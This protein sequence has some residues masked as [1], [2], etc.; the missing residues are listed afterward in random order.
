MAPRTDFPPVRACLFDMDGLLLDTEDLYTACINI[1]LEQNGRPLLPWSIKA[2]LQGRPG[3]DA[4]RLFHEWAQLPIPHDE[5]Q[6]KLSALQRQIFPATKPLPGVPALLANLGRT[7]YWDLSPTADGA[8][9]DKKN[10]RVHIAL[11]TSSHLANFKL[12]SDHLT[13]LFS[14]FPSDRR[15]LGD[16]K[17]IAPGRG[18]PN[19]DIFLLALKTINDSLPAGESPI[20]PEECLVFE[21]SVPG[22]EAGRRAGMRV[23][24]CPHKM[25][26]NEYAGRE[27]EVLAGRTGEAG[28]VDMHLVGEVDDG[29]AEYLPTLENFPYEK[30]GI[31][32]PPVEVDEEPFMKE[33][34]GDIVADKVNGSA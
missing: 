19:P 29:W 34:V 16:D 6:T 25:L 17:R 4:T 33:N 11:A 12:K 3:P 31:A 30:F 21:D 18:K 14:V 7:R 28:Q 22:V 24:W 2:K 9:D 1:I 26:L 23:I 15:V 5:Y 8:A 27:K 20:K 10:S 13:E 32:I